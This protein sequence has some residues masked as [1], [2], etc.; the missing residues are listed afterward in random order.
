MKLSIKLTAILTLLLSLS[1]VS[2]LKDNQF[3][4]G[5]IQSVHGGGQPNIVEVKLAASSA[6]QLLTL[7]FDNSSTDTT[8]N[9][10]PVHLSNGPASEDLQVTLVQKNSLVTDYNAAN[11]TGYK[12]PP[13][14][15]FTLVNAGGV[16]TIPKGTQ[17]AYLRIK[18]KP[19]DFLGDSWAIGYEISAVDKSSYTISGNLKSGIVAIGV[20]NEYEGNYLTTGF[21]SHPTAPRDIDQ[22]DFLATIGPRTVS[23]TLGDLTGTNINITVNAN[24]TVSI[25]PGSGTSGTSASVAAISGD[26]VYN[27][28]YVP[29]TKT[30]WLKYGYPNP[31]PTRIITEKVVRE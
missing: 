4:D 19:S 13:A 11:G 24:N 27:N 17:T 12:I 26:P 30:F 22:E 21:F 3:D 23:K 2:C 31:G 29:A 6:V 18:L 9:L 20:K 7:T 1:M 8:F 15:M 25:A 28:T 16:V 10:I 14:S 5:L